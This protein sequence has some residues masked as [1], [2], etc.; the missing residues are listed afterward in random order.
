[1]RTP[2][3]LFAAS[4]LVVAPCLAGCGGT[5]YAIQAGAAAS[6]VEEAKHLGAE[7]LAPYEYHF[8]HEHLLK[9]QSEAAEGD[10]SDALDFA[11]TAEQYADRA[12]KLTREAHRGAGR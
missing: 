8:A 4:V 3:R 9:A 5:M 12:I 2:L 11:E 1:M 6:K 10:Y 7:K